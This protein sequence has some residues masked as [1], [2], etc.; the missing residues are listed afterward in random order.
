MR[1]I[2]GLPLDGATQSGACS[3]D[4][5]GKARS[6]QESSLGAP[7]IDSH[8]DFAASLMEVHLSLVGN[9]TN[10]AM[11]VL[12]IISTIFIPLSFIAGVYGMNFNTDHPWNMP[13]LNQ[14]HGYPMVLGAMAAIAAGIWIYIRKKRWI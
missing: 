4:C 2:N 5:V 1:R 9:R 3:S 8:R 14:P 12:T 13:E 6:R 10:E 11:K 7:R